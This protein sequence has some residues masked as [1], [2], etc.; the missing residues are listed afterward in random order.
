MIVL[1]NNRKIEILLFCGALIYSS[2]FLAKPL[3]AQNPPNELC[4]AIW[5]VGD[6]DSGT[7]IKW[8]PVCRE[9][10]V[11]IYQDLNASRVIINVHGSKSDG[12]RVL[13]QMR[14]ARSEA[15]TPD[16]AIFAPQFLQKKE[17][18]IE[19]LDETGYSTYEGFWYWDAGWRW[20]RESINS[21][22]ANQ[23]SSFSVMDWM[24]EVI[25]ANTDGLDE[26][27]IAGHSAGGQFVNRYAATTEIEQD[28]LIGEGIEIRYISANPHGRMYFTAERPDLSKIDKKD[29]TCDWNNDTIN[30][31]TGHDDN[32]YH[33]GVGGDLPE[34]NGYDRGRAIDIQRLK[35]NYSGREVIL[36]QGAKDIN[37]NV[38]DTQGYTR[39]QKANTYYKHLRDYFGDDIIKN[40]KKVIVPLVGHDSDNIFQSD[41]GEYYLFGPMNGNRDLHIFG[42]FEEDP[43]VTKKGVVHELDQ[44]Y[45]DEMVAWDS[46]YAGN[47][48]NYLNNNVAD[49]GTKIQD[50]VS[51]VF[52]AGNSIVLKSGFHALY[53][54]E[55]KAYA[56]PF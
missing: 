42:N 18:A 47:L 13:E 27:V 28:L 2:I 43:F 25:V 10:G 26:I 54:S 49:E 21:T 16:V 3:Y 33:L 32:E 38:S 36:L 23:I 4:D 39:Y 50:G 29:D 17:G 24:I 41:I 30:I 6:D 51:V 9:S 45:S 34:Y 11:S 19:Q 22:G 12:P 40:H 52:R 14:I 35:D 7:T 15:G 1:K 20:G 5:L 48:G 37:P 8:V 31:P 55:F 44:S 46:I 56:Q 53:G